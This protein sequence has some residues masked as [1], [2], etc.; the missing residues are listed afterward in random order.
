MKIDVLASSSEGNAYLVSDGTTHLLIECGIPI[1]KLKLKTNFFIPRPDACLVSHAHKDHLNCPVEL[2]RLGIPLYMSKETGG[3]ISPPYGINFIKH[4]ERFTVGSFVI[5]PLEMRHD[6]YCLGF[7]I[8]SR[9]TK[10]QLFFATDTCY[11]PY[12]LPSVEYIMVEA[13]YDLNIL[14]E[15]IMNGNIDP[16]M[17]NRL[18][19]SHMEIGNTIKWLEKQDLSRTKRIYLLHLSYGSSNAEE[20]KRRVMEATGVPVT[21]AEG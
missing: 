4:R 3:D 14:N 13:N 11:I 6:V 15:R 10:E 17:K 21:I 19:L 12:V 18:A 5:Q 1:N 8:Y 7:Y 16:A 20:F 9:V 2:M